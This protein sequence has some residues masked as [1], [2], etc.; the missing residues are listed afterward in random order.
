MFQDRIAMAALDCWICF[1]F[2]LNK[3]N[4][5]RH[6]VTSGSI[7]TS[8]HHQFLNK[9]TQSLHI[10]N[11]QSNLLFFCSICPQTFFVAIGKLRELAT[12]SNDAGGLI[13]RLGA[14]CTSKTIHPAYVAYSPTIVTKYPSYYSLTET[15]T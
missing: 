9:V 2:D 5:S 3:D 10:A 4:I 8:F 12:S 14:N 11:Q 1:M 7:W 15:Q 13:G 6:F